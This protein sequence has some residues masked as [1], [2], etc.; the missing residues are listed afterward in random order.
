VFHI[1]GPATELRTQSELCNRHFN[2]AYHSRYSES[3]HR[4]L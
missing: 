2:S 3:W 1:Q 4:R